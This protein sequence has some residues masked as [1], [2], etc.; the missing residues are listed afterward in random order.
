MYK[1]NASLGSQSHELGR[2]TAFTPGWLE[3][4]SVWLHME[5]KYLFELLRSG[6]YEEFYQ[7]FR[8]VLIPF[9]KPER[10]GHSIL[11][12][13]SFIVSSAHLDRSLHGRGFVARLSG[14]TAEFIHIWLQMCLGRRPF[15]LDEKGNLCLEFRPILAQW[16]FTKKKERC[17]FRDQKGNLHQLSLPAHTLSFLLLGQSLVVYHN[18]KRRNTFGKGGVKP[19]RI[20]LVDT[21]GELTRVESGRLSAPFAQQVREGKFLRLDIHLA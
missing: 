21:Q 19:V 18:P 6:L 16:L 9:Q 13:S 3:N 11:E 1:V 10:Y 15:F 12:N 4:E 8:Q 2:T 7:D 14:S 5:Y 20:E 17:S